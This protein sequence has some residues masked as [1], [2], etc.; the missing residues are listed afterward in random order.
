MSDSEV[1][2]DMIVCDKQEG[3]IDKILLVNVS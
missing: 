2:L 1:N 3:V